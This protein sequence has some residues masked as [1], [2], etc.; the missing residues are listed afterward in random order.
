MTQPSCSVSSALP[1]A[2]RLSETAICRPRVAE[3]DSNTITSAAH[4]LSLDQL[5]LRLAGLGPL[6]DQ[7]GYCYVVRTVRLQ[8]GV[9]VQTGSAPN[10]SGGYITLNTCK[11]SMRVMLPA[12]QWKAGVWVAGMSS[13]NI[14]MGKQQS[15]VYLMRVAEGY[16]SQFELV[17]GLAS[18]GRMV[19]VEAK[20]STRQPLG[21]I[22]MPARPYLP[23]TDRH[24]PANYLPP[25]IEHAHRHHA[26]DTQWEQDVNYISDA[27][28]PAVLLVGDPRYSFTWSRRLIR[29]TKPGSL[30]PYRLWDL[31]TLLD[32]LEDFPA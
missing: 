1:V 17:Q 24:A 15:L 7:A 30:R 27:G 23:S 21:D 28:Q 29:N 12:E 8:N 25:M 11:H 22:L 20:N 32:N 16:D 13:W 4:N 3:V 26:T 5:S 19:T 10:F 2:R 6:E 14:E 9:L 18:S 31:G